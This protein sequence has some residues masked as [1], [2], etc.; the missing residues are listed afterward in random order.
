MDTIRKSGKGG[1]T[2][3]EEGSGLILAQIPSTAVKRIRRRKK[4]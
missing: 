2:N 3:R 1:E 4:K